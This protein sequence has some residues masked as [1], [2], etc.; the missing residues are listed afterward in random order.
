MKGQ[1]GGS[2]QIVV[3]VIHIMSQL[4]FQVF[5]GLSDFAISCE[6]TPTISERNLIVF[7][8]QMFCSS[9]RTAIH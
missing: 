5:K 9:D 3:F 4:Q 8:P 2:L 7:A 6:K 1:E